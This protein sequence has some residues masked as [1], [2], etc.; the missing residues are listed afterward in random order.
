MLSD[1]KLRIIFVQ[2][3][4]QQKSQFIFN[5]VFSAITSEN[6]WG[7]DAVVVVHDIFAIILFFMGVDEGN[8]RSRMQFLQKWNSIK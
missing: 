8:K 1:F 3:K 6:I 7:I 2:K 5:T 4:N